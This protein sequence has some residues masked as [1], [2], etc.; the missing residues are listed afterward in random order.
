MSDDFFS[1]LGL[2]I[3]LIVAG[4]AGGLIKAF[5]LKRASS[6]AILGSVVSGGFLAN[7]LSPV[8]NGFGTP[9]LV[10]AFLVGYGGTELCRRCLE[11]LLEEPSRKRKND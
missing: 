2:N 5:S 10:W 11:K 7:Y 9:P 4:F 8:L 3:K 1:L 6:W